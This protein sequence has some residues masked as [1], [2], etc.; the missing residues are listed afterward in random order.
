MSYYLK[1]RYGVKCAKIP[2]NAG[3][4]CPNRDGTVS[5]D[6]CTFCSVRG[7]GD[8][9]LAF[10]QDLMK[11]YRLNLERIHHKWPHARGIPYFQSFSNTYAPLRRLRQIYTPFL[12]NPD[13][14]CLCI[15]T[16][17]DCLDEDFVRWIASY[18]KDIWIELGLQSASDETGR[19][20]NRGYSTE[21]VSRALALI[22]KYGLF[23]CVHIINSL[24]GETA[25][26]MIDTARWAAREHPD[27]V[28][29][30]ML[31]LIS[32]TRMANDYRKEPFSLLSLDEYAD[33]VC[34]QLELLPPDMVI[35]RITGDGMQADLI[36]P[37][38]TL[39]KTCVSNR[40]D[41]RMFERN[42]WQGRLFQRDF[43][44]EDSLSKDS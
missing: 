10:D 27:A 36:E 8:S 42:T 38:W 1:K 31:H 19:R 43:E 7:S 5:T 13:I 9:I 16:R 17:A 23:S 44:P 28:K 40:I 4:T 32:G 20:I 3:F 18:H 39:K 2:L 6:G 34:D 29:I 26:T 11:Q 21:D 25:Q 41:T 30:H 37:L 12:E 35:E 15:A 22:R 14:F 24:P 33:L